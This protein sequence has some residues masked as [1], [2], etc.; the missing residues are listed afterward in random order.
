MK[1]EQT[2][3]PH[4]ISLWNELTLLLELKVKESELQYHRQKM[5]AMTAYM[6]QEYPKWT[7]GEVL[8]AYRLGV[9]SLLPD[10]DGQ[11]LE[12]FAELNPR[13]IGKVLNAY[14]Q[15]KREELGRNPAPAAKPAGLLPE[16]TAPSQQQQD[17]SNAQLFRFACLALEKGREYRDHGNL[18][19]DWLDSK[20]LIPFEKERKWAF[21]KQ[22]QRHIYNEEANYGVTGNAQEH[23][24]ARS[25]AELLKL[26][27]QQNELYLPQKD[28]IITRA[29]QI[30]FV[31][32]L[33]EMIEF[34]TTPDD[35]LQP[36]N[37]SENV[38]NENEQ[39]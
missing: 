20:G 5:K 25:M 14:E 23:K 11:P 38:N 24:D 1:L 3:T 31:T 19:Y 36:L 39:A 10:K 15:F 7:L 16:P 2:S 35:F 6:Q 22:A 29:K 18:L 26:A 8:L 9:K 28:R 30:A 4:F 33:K 34:E 12:M 13:S 32:L 21:M 17:R 27:D 37:D